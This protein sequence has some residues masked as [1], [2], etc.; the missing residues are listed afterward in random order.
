VGT[1]TKPPT[2]VRGFKS[3]TCQKSTLVGCGDPESTRSR[4]PHNQDFEKDGPFFRSFPLFLSQTESLTIMIT[5]SD[6]H[7][8]P[9]AISDFAILPSDSSM[10]GQSHGD[11]TELLSRLS[12]GDRAAEEQLLPLI[13]LQL[14][15]LAA[16]QLRNERSDHTL[17]PTALV[18][19]AYL[20][21]CQGAEVAWQDRAHFFRVSA[22][23][24]RRILVD[25]ARQR[26]AAKRG[27]GQQLEPINEDIL[28][29]NNQLALALQISEL[30]EQLAAVAPRL[31]QVVE[32][33]FFGGLSEAEIAESLGIA[34]RT[35]KRDWQKAQAW[36]HERMQRVAQ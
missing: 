15:R 27:A 16:A 25:Y 28:S 34:E 1:R 20:R 4:H 32:L 23:L 36:L 33:R 24:M 9:A 26:K 2:R 21:I 17:Q 35:V 14:R 11:V 3:L 10:A 30:L 22:K 6:E 31:E 29:A 19:E 8:S 13:Y 7:L 18:H 12:A 5:V